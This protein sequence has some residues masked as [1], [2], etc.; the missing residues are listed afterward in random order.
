MRLHYWDKHNDSLLDLSYCYA[1]CSGQRGAL[2]SGIVPSF[3]FVIDE[4]GKRGFSFKFRK[5]GS[6]RERVLV[7]FV[8]RGGLCAHRKENED[9]NRQVIGFVSLPMN[10]IFC[11]FQGN[12]IIPP[13]ESQS[14]TMCKPVFT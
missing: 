10:P 4:R 11:L 13:N 5:R 9:T 3:P 7:L 14:A 12:K 1:P 6:Q 8:F 2:Q